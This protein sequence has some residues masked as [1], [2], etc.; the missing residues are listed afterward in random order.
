MSYVEA[1]TTKTGAMIAPLLPQ[2]DDHVLDYEPCPWCAGEGWAGG[3]C[4]DEE[5]AFNPGLRFSD[6]QRCGGAGHIGTITR[7]ELRRRRFEELVFNTDARRYELQDRDVCPDCG[8]G[9]F[10]CVDEDGDRCRGRSHVD[11]LVNAFT[12]DLVA[13]IEMG[14]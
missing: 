14:A 3:G 9:G 13:V 11:Y 1:F 7:G 5:L 10:A 4:D 8:A 2:K 12:G 6:C